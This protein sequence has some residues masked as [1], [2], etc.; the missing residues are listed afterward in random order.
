MIFESF[1]GHVLEHEGFLAF[2]DV[3]G[4]A[5]DLSGLQTVDE[6]GSVDDLASRCVDNDDV[7]LHLLDGFLMITTGSILSLS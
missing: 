6:V 1:L 5:K 3:Q 4:G 7:L 2:K